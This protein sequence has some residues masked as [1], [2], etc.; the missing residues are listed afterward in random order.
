VNDHPLDHLANALVEDILNTSTDR[1]LAEAA[2]DYGDSRTL[3][4]AFDA[5]RAPHIRG[6]GSK[7]SASPGTAKVPRLLG[8]DADNT[9]PA[10]N[11]LLRDVG[12]N[13][14]DPHGPGP[15]SARARLSVPGRIASRAGAPMLRQPAAWRRIVDHGRDRVLTMLA[16]PRVARIAAIALAAMLLLGITT[17]G[18]LAVR[19]EPPSDGPAEPSPALARAPRILEFLN[20]Y[21]GGP[22]FLVTPLSVADG[23][24]TLDAF[25]S[26]P[27]PFDRLF[28]N[29]RRSL[30]FSA[31][32]ARH[33]VA[34]P[35]CPAIAFVA[36]LRPNS[37]PPLRVILD[38]PRGSEA[39]SGTITGGGNRT[40]DLLR[41]APDGS[42]FRLTGALQNAG[43]RKTFNVERPTGTI[44]PAE[45]QLLIAV[46][47]TAPVGAAGASSPGIADQV[48]G[49]M[50]DDTQRSGASLSL[51]MASWSA[52]R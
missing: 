14:D 3:A 12:R 23:R 51:G 20:S 27:A 45:L 35:Q 8:M 2:E 24:A 33:T 43:E 18:I 41:V 47:G 34:P 26:A 36:R 17:A 1:L 28:E 25:G 11:R 38:D 15:A 4:R 46:T 10:G 22:C 44:G 21:D 49:R 31:T 9:Q 42:V 52:G 6:A 29:F 7:P 30:G 5:A 39:I 48:F 50:L 32:V 16:R 13:R 19:H 37:G 40:I